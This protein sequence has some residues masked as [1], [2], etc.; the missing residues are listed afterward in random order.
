MRADRYLTLALVLSLLCHFFLAA[1]IWFV[2]KSYLIDFATPFASKIP[3]EKP[4][5][6]EVVLQDKK[7][8]QQIVRQA[9]APE[10]QQ[11]T[12]VYDPARFLSEKKQ[13]VVLE[14][15]AK[16]TGKTQNRTPTMPRY[17]RELLEKKIKEQLQTLAKESDGEITINKRTKGENY[18][19]MELFPK[20]QYMRSTVGDAL[21]SDVS[22]GDF[23]ALNTDQYQFYTFYARVEDLVR[24]RWENHVRNA[25]DYFDRRRVIKNISQKTWITQ[26]EFLINAQGHLVKA[27]LLKES[28]VPQFDQSSVRAF[29]D[30]KVFPNPPK[31]MI[32]SDGFIHLRYS[33]HVYFNPSYLAR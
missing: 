2:P 11:E 26:I 24:F 28:G 19:P 25:I 5:L 7:E 22:V 4:S 1:I 9:D 3:V 23:T 13:R 18:K 8:T 10:D 20:D 14:T 30:A 27:I 16:E 29:E 31:E 33:F 21:P 6:I 12:K 17:Q 15:Q 32:Q